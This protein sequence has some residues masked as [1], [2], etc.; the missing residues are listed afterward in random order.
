VNDGVVIPAS[1]TQ[2]AGQITE[3][4]LARAETATSQIPGVA[5]ST[6]TETLGAAFATSTSA[7]GAAAAAPVASPPAAPYPPVAAASHNQGAPRRVARRGHTIRPAPASRPVRPVPAL[8][9]ATAKTWTSASLDLRS[10]ISPRPA[11]TRSRLGGRT[12]RRSSGSAA[13]ERSPSVAVATPGLFSVPPSTGSVTGAAGGGSGSGPAI[14]M[15]LAFT[16]LLV[17]VLLAGRLSLDVL[18]WHSTLARRPPERPG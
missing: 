16:L 3:T 6:V 17:Q 1:A 2:L 4:A 5:Q 10:A 7:T 8:S 12:R 13:G 9:R 18:P 11:A 14:A 15:L